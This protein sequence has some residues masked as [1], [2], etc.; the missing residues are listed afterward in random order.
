MYKSYS[1]LIE[2]D[3]DIYATRFLMNNFKEIEEKVLSK[4]DTSLDKK[5]P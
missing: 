2:A 3:A 5:T 1:D 4:Y